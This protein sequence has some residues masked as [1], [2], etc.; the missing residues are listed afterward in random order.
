MQVVEKPEAV[1]EAPFASLGQEIQVYWSKLP[2][3]AAFVGLLAAWCLL[4]YYYGWTSTLAGRTDSLFGWMW[5]K[6]NDPSNDSSHG[7]IIP[8]VVVGLLWFRRKQIVEVVSGVWWPGLF[9]VGFSLLLHVLGFVIQQPRF[10]MVGLFSGMWFL[11]GLVW[12]RDTLKITFFPFVI[13]AFCVPMGG[14]FAQGLTLPLRLFAARGAE[15]ITKGLLQVNVQRIGTKL[16]DPTGVYGSFDV[17]AECSG[18]RSFVALLAIT[19]IFSVL[20]MRKYWKR[21]VM[22]L[23]TIPLSLICNIMR[24]TTIV[25]AANEFK[26]PKAGKFVDDYFGYVTYAVAIGGMLLL[27]RLLKEETPPVSP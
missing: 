16:L 20:T 9:G 27:A 22:I 7:K 26:T 12:G 1:S 18:I 3:G 4:F 17:A 13:F 14:T 11:T 10:S 2:D 5:D 19:T 6:W 25:M 24:V 21:A 23:S 8:F 15:F